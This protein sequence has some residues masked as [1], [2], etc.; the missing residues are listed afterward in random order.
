MSAFFKEL[1]WGIKAHQKAYQFIKKHS[2]WHFFIWPM[3]F[4]FVVFWIGDFYIDQAVEFTQGYVQSWYGEPTDAEPSFWQKASLIGVKWTLKLLFFY[5]YYSINKYLVFIF[6]SPVLAIMSEKVEERATDKKFPFSFQQ[7]SKDIMRG[8]MIACR[9]I[10]LEYS[11][12]LLLTI[13]AFFFPPLI[14]INPFLIFFIQ[15]YFYGFAFMDYGS[16]R[17]KLNLSQSV[18]FIRRHKGMAI[19]IGGVFSLI[20]MV[21]F[22]GGIIAPVLSGVAGT[23]G[24]LKLEEHQYKKITV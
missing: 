11:I 5:L 10:F 9:N 1:S 22:I 14:I 3:A 4:A 8:V 23:L 7:F 24:Y 18:S 17:R 2:L 20:F 16:E 19:G 21:P 13:T 12:T 15:S 6:L